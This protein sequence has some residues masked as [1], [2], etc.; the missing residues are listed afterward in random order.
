MQFKIFNIAIPE[1]EPD[2][3][4]MNRFLRGNRIVAVEKQLINAGNVNYWSFCVQYVSDQPNSIQGDRKEKIDY[5]N[6]L[7]ASTFEI[8][9]KLRVLRKQIAESDAVP[10]YA[11]YTDAELAEIARL[12]TITPKT[13][14]TINGIGDKRVEKYGKILCEMIGNKENK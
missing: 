13:L 14:L 11:V 8:F 10:A 5:K 4:E 2:T 3:E 6:V 9:S 12:E 1:S 7:D